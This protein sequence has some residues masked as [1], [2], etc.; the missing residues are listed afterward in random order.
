MILKNILLNPGRCCPMIRVLAYALKS[1]PFDAWSRYVGCKFD[2]LL[3]LEH[4][5]EETNRCYYYFE[6]FYHE[7]VLFDFVMLFMHLLRLSCVFFFFFHVVY[8]ID[9]FQILNCP[10][11]SEINI[12]LIQCD[13]F[14]YCWTQ[15]ASIMLRIFVP[16]HI[17]H[18]GL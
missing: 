9:W 6:C 4:I 7:I 2:P 12:S 1:L 8:Y 13:G 18:T 10:C 11:I 15:F 3:W 16:I 14:I 17:R 5:W